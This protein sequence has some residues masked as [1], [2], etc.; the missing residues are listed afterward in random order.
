MLNAEEVKWGYRYVL[1]RDPEGEGIVASQAQSFPDWQGL[2]ESLFASEEFKALPTYRGRSSKWVASDILGGKRTIWLDLGDDFVSRAALMDSYETLET[3]VVSALSQKGDVFLDIGANIGW[4]T[5]LA[6]TL[7]G[8]AGHIHA[9]EP[10]EPTLGYLRRTIAM[11]R[12]QSMVT[13]HDFGLGDVGGEF[14][15]GWAHGS[16]NPGSAHLVG[17][18]SP[19]I[20]ADKIQIKT[21]DA[22]NMPKIDFIRLDVE[23]AEPR[24]IAGGRKAIETRCPIILSELYPEQLRVDGIGDLSPVKSPA[25]ARDLVE[26]R[27]GTLMARALEVGP[28]EP[29]K[30]DRHVVDAERLRGGEVGFERMDAVIV[31]ARVVGVAPPRPGADHVDLGPDRLPRGVGARVALAFAPMPPR[32]VTPPESALVARNCVSSSSVCAGLRSRPTKP[33]PHRP[34]T[35]RPLWDR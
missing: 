9:F 30:G 10:R 11:N 33:R 32:I 5:L 21:L 24:V 14:L 4:Y 23:G 7:V 16:R 27:L 19:Q 1:G 12:L 34:S 15:L 35:G 8:R 26:D 18:E 2:R 22:L 6:S 28:A 17:A 31:G 25:A 3:G 20:E 13:V 29:G